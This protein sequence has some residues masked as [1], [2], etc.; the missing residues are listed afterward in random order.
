MHVYV[1]SVYVFPLGGILVV[2][3]G[4]PLLFRSCVYQ[5]TTMS[6]A[7]QGPTNDQGWWFSS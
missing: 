3:V 2:E 1:L 6:K 4:V 7:G 5:P